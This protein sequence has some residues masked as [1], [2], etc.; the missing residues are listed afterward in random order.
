MA[1]IIEMAQLSPTMSEGTLVK[2]LKNKNEEIEVG[3]ILAEVETDKSVMELDALEKG[4]L[5][6]ILIESGSK[7][8]IGQPIAI[9]GK[10][11]EDVSNLI[12][13]LKSKDNLENSSDSKTVK[14]DDFPTEKSLTQQT[15]E[16]QIQL[17][18]K[19]EETDS[20]RIKASPL[21]KKLALQYMINL[22]KVKGSGP[23]G[24]ILKKDLEIYLNQKDSIL[25][26]SSQ[27]PTTS[28]K[29]LQIPEMRNVIAKRLQSS[30]N[31]IP[32]FYLNI[33]VD[34]EP[35]LELRR[36]INEDLK[37]SQKENP[38]KI[39]IND[40][41]IKATA[42]SLLMNPQVNCSWKNDHILQHYRIDIGV[43]VAIENGLLTPYIRNAD[44]LSLSQVS[45][46]MKELAQKAR[47]R[48]LKP[49]EYTDGCLSISNLGMY[50][51]DSF[52][53]IINEPESCILAIGGLVEKP[54][55]K[56]SSIVCGKTITITLSCDH[57][58]IDGALGARFLDSF[59]QNIEN[60][61]KILI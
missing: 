48:K 39:S 31:N 56:N 3:D 33:E 15:E 46:K 4:T 23:K 36:E 47:D 30:K 17:E 38:L 45:L 7:V 53:A 28:S 13:E 18:K 41:I 54:V 19:E 50:G 11:D 2:W 37:K 52:S 60:P 57:R 32:H 44:K 59:K 1:K 26:E 43:A 21:A 61:Y 9:V 20:D 51:I 8:K 27:I 12:K 42:L 34:A 6:A 24:R 49:E 40:F 25:T 29:K 5:L 10:K 14:D 55:I 58:V 35:V 16:V 22:S